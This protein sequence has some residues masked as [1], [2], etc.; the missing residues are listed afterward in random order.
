M[1]FLDFLEYLP[2]I[3]VGFFMGL[4]KALRAEVLRED[5]EDES[6]TSKFDVLKIFIVEGIQGAV[7]CFVVYGLLSL[8][9]LPYIFKVCVGALIAYLGIDKAME[10]VEKVLS[11]R[12]K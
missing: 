5:E 3:L 7:F 11:I 8:T 9:E 2:L 1:N 4:F 10:L 6:V 12:K